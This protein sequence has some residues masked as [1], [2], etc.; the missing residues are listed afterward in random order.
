MD[1]SAPVS[2]FQTEKWAASWS[3]PQI[4]TDHKSKTKLVDVILMLRGHLAQATFSWQSCSSPPSRG[5]AMEVL[6]QGV[7]STDRSTGEGRKLLPG[8]VITSAINP[9]LSGSDSQR[10]TLNP[11]ICINPSAVIP[12]KHLFLHWSVFRSHEIPLMCCPAREH[13]LHQ[14]A[15]RNAAFLSW[16]GAKHYWWSG[17]PTARQHHDPGRTRYPTAGQSE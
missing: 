3:D 16:W 6:Q 13:H 12:A 7:Q 1:N 2:T 17:L 4:G 14:C 10:N 11:F 5:T 8:L 9:S 15:A